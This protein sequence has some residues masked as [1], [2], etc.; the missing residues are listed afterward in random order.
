[1]S[2]LELTFAGVPDYDRIGPL[3]SGVVQPDGIHL[4]STSFSLAGEVFRRVAQDAAF[5]VA[6]MSTSTFIAMRSRDDDR[7]VGLPIFPYRAFRHG[8]MWVRTNA[9]ITRPE[10]LAT[11]RI[12]LTE[13]QQTASLWLRGILQDEYGVR[14]DDVQWVTG[15]MESSEPERFPVTLPPRIK[16]EAIPPDRG[17]DSMLREG[18]IDALIGARPPPSFL[19]SDPQIQRLIPDYRAAER[20]YFQRTG[21]FPI[22]HMVV[23]RRSVYEEHPWTA[24]VLVK[25]FERV[26]DAGITR[27]WDT[28]TSV[29]GLPW[30]LA[31]MEEIRAVFGGD[32]WP[33]GVVKNRKALEYML[34]MS[35]DQGI[36]PRR[37][38]VEGLFAK[39]TID[40]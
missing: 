34:Q 15:G 2:D 25:T 26:K 24:R 29:C 38:A 10:Q 37:L 20:A 14:T 28:E 18:A 3:L 39:N 17:L 9:G 35:Y 4:T 40:T 23:L 12:G 21:F 36:S 11:A 13:Y 5:D 31:D 30:L 6:E 16:L 8:F 7:Y 32:P 19:R 22:M 1:M 27:L 33:Y